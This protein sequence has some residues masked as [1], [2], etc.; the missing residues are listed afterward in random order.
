[1]PFVDFGKSAH[2]DGSCSGG[3]GRR[4]CAILQTLL[5]GDAIAITYDSISLPLSLLMVSY[6][7]QCNNIAYDTITIVIT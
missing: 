1:M 4:Q 7:Y 6:H 2:R 5:S 3:G